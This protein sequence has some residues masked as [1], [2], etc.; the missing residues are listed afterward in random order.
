MIS[1]TMD[2]LNGWIGQFLWPFMRLTGLI[3]VAPIFSHRAVPNLFKIG[4]AFLL[5]VAI[6]PAI[7]HIPHIDI[8]SWEA[9][10]VVA[11]QTVIGL[12]MGFVMQIIFT[13]VETGGEFIGLQ[14]GLSFAQIFDPANGAN[15]AVL[16]QFLSIIT[17]MLFLAFDGHL[18]ILSA[19]VH[20]F[21]I[22][23]I[24]L[25]ALDRNG[26]SVIVQWGAAIFS[27][28][29]LL[30]LPLICALLVMNL[31]LGIL[32][33]AAPQLTVFS[34]GFPVT[35]ISGLLLLTSVLPHSGSYFEALFQQGFETLDHLLSGLAGH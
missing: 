16:S 35:L 11:E 9:L 3:L 13:A 17:I 29:L 24:G 32:N 7:S 8:N 26:W 25:G 28:G 15:T 2:Q 33:R 1:F 21:D 4:L 20:S 6:A 23:P 19:L 10:L 30:S 34:I 14:M 12:A 18:L 27:Y 31:S 5:T 22:L